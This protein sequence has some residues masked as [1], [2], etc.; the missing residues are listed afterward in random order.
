MA[1]AQVQQAA[2]AELTGLLALRAEAGEL[3]AA[4][5]RKLRSLQRHTE[6]EILQA[7]MCCSPAAAC[8]Q[9]LR[10]PRSGSGQ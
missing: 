5:E 8:S 3:S 2:S 1:A 6:R 9:A 7:S 10:C 4:D